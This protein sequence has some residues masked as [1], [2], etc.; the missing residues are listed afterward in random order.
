MKANF[1]NQTAARAAIVQHVSFDHVTLQRFGI[2]L[3]SIS[4]SK[5]GLQMIS[6]STNLSSHVRAHTSRVHISRVMIKRPQPAPCVVC[7]SQSCNCHL[8]V[9]RSTNIIE[10]CELNMHPC[11]FRPWKE[12]DNHNGADHFGEGHFAVASVDINS[13]YY[14]KEPVLPRQ[15]DPQGFHQ[16]GLM[17]Q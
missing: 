6:S 10:P 1:F 8:G 12:L 15:D 4:I 13:F 9:R 3:S 16:L 2:S 5:R 17:V 14:N 11:V 7:G